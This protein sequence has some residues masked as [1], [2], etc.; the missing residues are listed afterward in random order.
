MVHAQQR[1]VYV[2]KSLI[3]LAMITF[4][5]T[6]STCFAAPILGPVHSRI[7]V[8]GSSPSLPIYQTPAGTGYDGVGA[9][10]LNTTTTPEGFITFCTGSVL[11]GGRDVLTAAH[12]VSDDAGN[13]TLTGGS[14]I[15]LPGTGA[16][17]IQVEGASVHPSWDGNLLAG[18]DLAIIRLT[19]PV[20]PS[21]QTYSLFTGSTDLG[22][23][24]DVVGFGVTGTGTT[25]ATGS[26]GAR[27]RGANEFDATLQ[28]MGFGSSSVLMSDFDDGTAAHDGFGFFYGD[29]G[30]GLGITEVAT[31]PGDSGGPAFIGGRIA[32][33]T[34]FG[35]RLETG[36]GR[37]S[38]IDDE[39]NSTF[40]EFDGFTRVS[41]YNDWISGPHQ[42]QLVPEPGTYALVG[43]GLGVAALIRRRRSETK[44]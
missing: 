39:L 3:W 11:N 21:I 29:T 14:A 16:E 12:C 9:L 8:A 25:G 22:S 24:Y 7:V 26:I 30:R 37:S 27:R 20:G 43:L 18:Y 33:I 5:A 1:R 41:D 6:I 10:L 2:K 13:L 28:T 32:G 15:F 44:L 42:F 34:S 36:T 19:K 31:A 23:A 35:V 38:D 4:F 40:G 17:E